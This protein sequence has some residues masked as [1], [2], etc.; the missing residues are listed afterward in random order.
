MTEGVGKIFGRGTDKIFSLEFESE[1][2]KKKSLSRI[3]PHGYRLFA[4]FRGTIL[5]W[6]G[7]HVYCLANATESYGADLG[8]CQQ[9]PG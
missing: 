5:T 2:Q 3:T 4:N 9:M 7:G 1:D 6:G 8:S